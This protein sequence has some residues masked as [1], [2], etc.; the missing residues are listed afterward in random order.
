MLNTW[1]ACKYCTCGAFARCEFLKFHAPSC[2]SE[3]TKWN[4]YHTHGT[5]ICSKCHLTL[6]GISQ[7]EMSLN[8]PSWTSPW[9]KR[10]RIDRIGVSSASV[11]CNDSPCEKG[12]DG[13]WCGVPTIYEWTSEHT[14]NVNFQSF[15]IHI[16][17]DSYVF[18]HFIASKYRK[19]HV[20]NG[21]GQQYPRFV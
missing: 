11:H 2:P 15:S 14:W 13:W 9:W 19:W 12:G 1:N 20:E 17:F 10:A 7:I 3:G 16:T 21:R 18:G 6:Y 8:M 5:L 4:G